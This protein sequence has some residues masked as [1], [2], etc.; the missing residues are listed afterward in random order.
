MRPIYNKLLLSRL[1]QTYCKDMDEGKK[2]GLYDP[3]PVP[4]EEDE[5]T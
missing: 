2:F 1:S 5:E 4:N 3:V